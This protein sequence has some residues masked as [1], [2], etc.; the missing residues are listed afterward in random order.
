M[1]T[2]T[3]T[4]KQLKKLIDVP[5]IDRETMERMESG[6]SSNDR[7]IE[8]RITLAAMASDIK[9]LAKFSI[10]KPEEF[11]YMREMIESFKNHAHALLEVAESASLRMKISDCRK[12]QQ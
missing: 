9:K 1:A 7:G 3:L 11:D 6:A 8:R 4:D 10:E 5:V 2:K 12:V